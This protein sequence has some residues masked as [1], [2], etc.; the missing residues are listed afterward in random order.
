MGTSPRVAL[1]SREA[2]LSLVLGTRARDHTAGFEGV[3]PLSVVPR[4]PFPPGAAGVLCELAASTLSPVVSLSRAMCEELLLPLCREGWLDGV[5]DGDVTNARRLRASHGKPW[6]VRLEARLPEGEG[7]AAIEFSGRVVRSAPL[8]EE[9]LAP[10][11]IDALLEVGYVVSGDE[12]GVLDA[13]C[14]AWVRSLREGPVVVPRAEVGEFMGA[15]LALPRGPRVTNVEDIG[16]SLRAGKPEPCLRL[17]PSVGNERLLRGTLVFRYAKGQGGLHAS[18]D[19][20]ASET[21]EQAARWELGCDMRPQTLVDGE[22]GLLV[23]RDYAEECAVIKRLGAAGFGVTVWEAETPDCPFDVRVHFDDFARACEVLM[24]EGVRVELDGSLLRRARGFRAFVSSEQDWFE[25]KGNARFDRNA[26]ELPELLDQVRQKN[27]FARLGDGSLGL[28]P[29]RWIAEFAP[30]AS[31]VNPK[32]ERL[33][34]HALQA[35][36]ID[37]LLGSWSPAADPSF[38]KMRERVQAFNGIEPLTEPAGFKGELRSY[39]R[40][41]LGWLAALDELG[42]SGCLADDMGLGKTVVVLA[43]LW[44]RAARA[45][46]GGRPSLLVVPKSLLFNWR[47]EARAFT[48]ELKLLVHHGAARLPPGEHFEQYDVVLTSYGTLR[49][50]AAALAALTFDYVVLDEAHAIKNQESLVHRSARRLS[51]RGRLALTGTPVENHLLELWALLNYLNPGVLERFE[52]LVRTFERARPSEIAVTEVIQKLARPFVLRRTK[53][54]VAPELPPRI[55]KTLYVPLS[56]AQAVVYRE[57]AD[58][59]RARMLERREQRKYIGSSMRGVSHHNGHESARALEALLRLRQVA[60]HPALLA[61]SD[62]DLES[63]AARAATAAGASSAKLDLL[64]EQLGALGEE[65]HKSLVFSQFTG[66]LKIVREALRERGIAFEYLDGETQN[67]QS[68]VERFQRREGAC[69]FL[70]SL[71]TGGTGLN[72]TAADYVFILDPWWNPAAET[73]AVDRAHRIGQTR[74][75]IAYRLLTKG[76]VEAKVAALQ[77]NKRALTHAIFSDDAAFSA[78]L[79]QKD[80]EYL[81]S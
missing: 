8:G 14:V 56:G 66:F 11:R 15:L 7:E 6:S 51:S 34:F 5:R 24:D 18:G 35:L 39:Q 23:Q 33:R 69:V 4:L 13:D 31:L 47:S 58:H 67:R 52:H 12:L 73:Q 36:L 3:A 60:C 20:V 61:G 37:G 40:V 19:G 26:L 70:I 71:K 78:K 28:L 53:D 29:E 81:L 62:V 50:D 46:R 9:T 75:V 2:T 1:A 42:L 16:Y 68:V 80:L 30:L 32:H 55:E 22:Q 54:E 76:T 74:P 17:A 77:A 43:F 48:P 79:T 45:P 25:L 57:L 72:L 21:D 49:R 63:P 59:Y 44:L 10:T 27:R 38:A 64:L 41:A 65:G